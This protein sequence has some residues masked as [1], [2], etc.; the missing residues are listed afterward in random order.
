MVSATT[1]TV[2]ATGWQARGAV[3][4]AAGPMSMTSYTRTFAILI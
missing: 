3:R 2:T 1:S 4:R